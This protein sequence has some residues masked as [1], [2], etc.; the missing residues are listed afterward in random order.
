MTEEQA[1]LLERA[2]RELEQA[3][4]QRRHGFHL[5]VLANST[6]LGPDARTVVLRGVERGDRILRFHSD[7]RSGKFKSLQSGDRVAWVFQCPQIKL[8]VRANG[9]M[10]I[11]T[12]GNLADEAWAATQLLSR[13]CYLAE[14]GPGTSV[15]FPSS[16]LPEELVDRE[17]TVEESC[18]GRE[19]FCVALTHVD[20]LDVYCL[21]YEGHRRCHFTFE[22]KAW[23]ADWRIP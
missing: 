4:N 6:P 15:P 18:A 14:P 5:G 9:V 8:Q 20:R 19:H 23:Q 2:W 12:Q 10:G 11:H 1:G 21:A 3:A 13:R 7:V 16:G 22:G 17:P